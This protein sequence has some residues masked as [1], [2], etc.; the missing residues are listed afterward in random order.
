M[1]IG[2]VARKAGIAT[3]AIR[4]Y[5]DA[6]LLPEPERTDSGYRIYDPA[7]V[8]R[9]A[10]IRAG[11]GVGLSLSELGDVLR[12]RDRGDAPCSHVTDL[13]DTRIKEIE[14]R[15]R[16]LRRMKKDLL[17]LADTA[18]DFDAA[19]CPPESVCRILTG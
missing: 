2:E 19:D 15:M 1:Q 18:A 4:F 3:S 11:Q 5:E 13:I 6:G 12:I 14:E 10:F 7:V 9:L 17:A 8:D 16:D